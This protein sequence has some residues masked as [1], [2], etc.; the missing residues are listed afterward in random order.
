MTALSSRPSLRCSPWFRYGRS[1][2]PS[3]RTIGSSRWARDVAGIERKETT[4]A[5]ADSFSRHAIHHDLI[6]SCTRPHSARRWRADSI[7]THPEQ[8]PPDFRAC[9]E[10][11][12]ALSV[13]VPP[14][15]LSTR[16]RCSRSVASYSNYAMET[17]SHG[18]CLGVSVVLRP[19]FLLVVGRVMGHGLNRACP[20]EHRSRG[21]RSRRRYL[22]VLTH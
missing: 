10:G 2:P 7:D 5:H 22:T 4:A 19:A 16:A 12:A 6:L 17:M 18:L 1:G 15:A 9:D 13:V 8:Q 11:A 14:S 21:H 3:Q 20:Q